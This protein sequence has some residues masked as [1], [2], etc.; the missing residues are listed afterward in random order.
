MIRTANQHAPPASLAGIRTLGLAHIGLAVPNIDE[1]RATYVAAFG[2]SFEGEEIVA[3]QR[4]RVCFL[5]LGEGPAA[6]R[7]ELLEPTDEAS[8]VAKFLAKRGA[9]LH[10]VA[11]EVAD[12]R[13]ALAAAHDAGLQLI[14][15][16]PR[17]GAHGA[18][19]A[20]LHPKSTGGLLTEL[21]RS[22]PEPVGSAHASPETRGVPSAVN[23]VA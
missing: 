9:G 19:I 15:Q 23:T 18:E 14:D 7:I 2:G 5:R 6:V 1:V 21:C 17:R 8:P 16:L 4:V 10:H 22:R 12:V 13:A 20:F 3:D 11:Y